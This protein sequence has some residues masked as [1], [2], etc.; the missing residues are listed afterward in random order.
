M[1]RFSYRRANTLLF[2]AILVINGYILIV[3][4]LPAISYW[5]H[6]RNPQ[7]IQAYSNRL[8][9][10]KPSTN[11]S[12]NPGEF[13][14]GPDH[15]GLVIPKML[16]DTPLVEGPMSN[17]FNLLNQGAW[18]LPISATPDEGGNT[19]IAGHRFSYTGPRGVFYYLNKLV[20]GDEIGLWYHGKLYLYSVVSS[21]TVNPTEVSVQQPTKDTRL[22]LYTCT[23]LWKPVN[24][25]IVVATPKEVSP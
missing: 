10:E 1:H 4:L 17:S 3:P 24:R 20:P 12:S 15:D 7:A 18:R 25:L 9:S 5:W 13:H 14:A 6:E 11:S 8:H 23:P 2:I 22:T 19:V 21:R 16:L